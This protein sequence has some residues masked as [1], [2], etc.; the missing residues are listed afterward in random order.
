MPSKFKNRFLSYSRLT[1]FEQCPL[2]FKLHYIEKQRAA[3]GEALLFGSLIHT[4]LE[5]LLKKV[6][7]EEQ[8]GKLSEKKALIIYRQEWTASRLTGIE[9]FQEGL[10]II[11]SFVAKNI[12]ID[13]WDL[14]AIEKD[15]TIQVGRFEVRGFIDRVDAVDSETIHVID[16]KTSRQLYSRDDLANNLQLSLY[17]AAAKRIW[18]WAK[19]VKASFYMLRHR[20]HQS[21]ERTPEQ[22]EAALSYMETLGEMTEQATEYPARLNTFCAYCD[23]RLHCPAYEDALKGKRKFI[24][25][26][27]SDLEAVAKEREEVTNLAK[28]LYAR[29][30]ELEKVLRTHLQDKDELNLCGVRYAM[31]KAATTKY[32]LGETLTTLEQASD[33]S[34][35]QIIDRIATID[36][37]ALES[38]ITK[39]GKKTDRSQILLLKAELDANAKKIYS[40]RLWAKKVNK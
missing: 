25:N 24:G 34:R 19:N 36:N 12:H 7:N 11:R 4:V 13:H 22:L 3:P 23:H 8:T 14:L 5:R 40:P 33:L 37:K 27:P 39:L 1:R 28:I 9:L 17:C 30:K 15:F 38:F 10:D 31:Y 35:D 29:K 16:Y 26:D 6:I 2:S 20:L 18:P 21:V 32:P